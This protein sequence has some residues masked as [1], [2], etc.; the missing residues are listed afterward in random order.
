MEN[1]TLFKGTVFPIN[2]KHK[3]LFVKPVSPSISA[4][5]RP[6]D[7]LVIA[8]P[9]ASTPRII[10]E[11]AQAGVKGAIIISAG[12]KETGAAGRELEQ[13]ILS[14]TRRRGCESSVPT[15]LA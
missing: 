14:H 9:A 15:A 3:T 6:P 7:L 2:P 1:L 13:E 5:P 10:S 4:L 11:C 12:F 8:T